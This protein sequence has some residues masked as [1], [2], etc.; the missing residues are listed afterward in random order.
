MM[1]YLKVPT[2]LINNSNTTKFTSPPHPIFSFKSI[3]TDSNL[4]STDVHRR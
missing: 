3:E 2:N 4:R 1:N